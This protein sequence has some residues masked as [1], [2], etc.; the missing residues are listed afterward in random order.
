MALY[1]TDAPLVNASICGI[2]GVSYDGSAYV[3][4]GTI[5]FRA[6]E[7]WTA[8]NHGTVIQFRTT[9]SGSGGALFEAMRINS[10]GNVGIGTTTPSVY[11]GFTTLEVGNT[12]GNAG[13]F[14]AKHAN[15]NA[16]MYN[17]GGIASFGSTGAYSTTFISQSVERMRIDTSGNLLVGQTSWNFSNN[18]TQIA[19]NGRIYN[20]SNTDYNLELAGSTSARIRFYTSAGGSGTT[21]GTITVSGSATTYAT[22]SDYRLKENVSPMTGALATVAQ[23]K[24]VTYTWKSDGSAGQGF[25]AHELQA[26]VPDCVTGTKDA[27]DAEGKPQYQGVDTSFLVATVVA[28]LQELKAEVDSLKAQ[29]QGAA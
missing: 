17:A 7:N 22:S 12:S 21:V 19:A 23:L 3:A 29:L 16:I 20:T 28:A 18:G 14:S 15:G 2:D 6:A 13:L 24:P 4:G 10:D 8:T 5:N 26:V 1:R 27:V 25:I 11:G 9:A